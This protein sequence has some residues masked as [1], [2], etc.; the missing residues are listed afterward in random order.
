MTSYPRIINTAKGHLYLT[1]GSREKNICDLC[2]RRTNC[3]W[4]VPAEITYKS[5]TGM[6]VCFSCAN[7]LK[8][9]DNLENEQKSSKACQRRYPVYLLKEC[10]KSIKIKV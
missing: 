4:Y 7:H 3:Y 10:K 1:E 5:I 9:D 2:G 6:D 8:V